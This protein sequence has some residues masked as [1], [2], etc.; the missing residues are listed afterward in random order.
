MFEFQDMVKLVQEITHIINEAHN[1]DRLSM[2][3]IWTNYY[4]QNEISIFSFPF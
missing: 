2:H 1:L 4:D 3:A